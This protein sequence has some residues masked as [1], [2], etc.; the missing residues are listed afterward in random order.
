MKAHST[1][2]SIVLIC[3]GIIA[4]FASAQVPG[5]FVPDVYYFNGNGVPCNTSLGLLNRPAGT[6]IVDADGTDMVAVIIGGADVISGQVDDG[7]YLVGATAF[8]PGPMA[9]APLMASS[10][11][12]GANPNGNQWIRTNPL[13]TEG[14]TGVIGETPDDPFSIFPNVGLADFGLGFPFE[15]TLDDGSG[16]MWEVT[17]STNGGDSFFTNVSGCIPDPIRCC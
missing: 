6:V 10:W 9:P 7:S 11:S 15:A 2:I 17:T 12:A 1:R 16:G 3:V 8:L 5:D 14:F 13:D 4:G